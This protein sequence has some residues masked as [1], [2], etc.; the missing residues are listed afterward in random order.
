MFTAKF[1][2]GVA[3]VPHPEKGQEAAA[4]LGAALEAK[5]RARG[6]LWGGAAQFVSPAQPP[7]PQHGRASSHRIA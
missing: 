4:E 5:A 1:F 7:I 6:G 3:P 2:G